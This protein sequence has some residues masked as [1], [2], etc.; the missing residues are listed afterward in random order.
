MGTIY[1]PLKKTQTFPCKET[2]AFW[3]GGAHQWWQE[4]FLGVDRGAILGIALRECDLI[5]SVCDAGTF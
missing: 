5:M 4:H 2:W 3:W 1:K